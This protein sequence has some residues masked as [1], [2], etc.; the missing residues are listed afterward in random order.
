MNKKTPYYEII[1]SRFREITNGT[2]PKLLDNPDIIKKLIKYLSEIQLI[3][4]E[5]NEKKY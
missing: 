1:K 3:Q 2:D 5:K 4:L